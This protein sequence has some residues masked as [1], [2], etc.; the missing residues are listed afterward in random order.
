MRQ[1]A[2]NVA[3][4][5]RHR[6]R[7][8]IYEASV[9]RCLGRFRFCNLTSTV[10]MIS[11]GALSFCLNFGP[12]SPDPILGAEIDVAYLFSDLLL[13]GYLSQRGGWSREVGSTIDISSHNP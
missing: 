6:L 7:G 9:S 12:N 5:Q 1:R 2:P 10:L 4:F 3:S 11:L 8:L 13:S